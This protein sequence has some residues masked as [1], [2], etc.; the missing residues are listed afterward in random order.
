[1]SLKSSS[2]HPAFK[3]HCAAPPF[4]ILGIVVTKLIESQAEQWDHGRRRQILVDS[5]LKEIVNGQI[6]PGQHLVTQGLARRFGVSHT[7]VREAL[8]MLAGMGLVDVAPNRGAVVRRVTPREVREICQVRSA[9]ECEAVRL[10]CGR[11]DQEELEDLRGEL[12]AVGAINS[13]DQHVTIEVARAVDNRLH[14][15]ISSRCGNTFLAH[16]LSRLKNLFR[17]FR[18]AAWNHS[19][20]RSDFHRIS[21]EAKEHLAI[22]DSLLAIDR[23]RAVRAMARH[24]ASGMTYWSE[25]LP[26]SKA[27]SGSKQGVIRVCVEGELS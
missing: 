12:V 7:P 19:E 17:A 23:P 10:A 2:P 27:H 18:D 8:I 1:M 24:I 11:I 6:R 4:L 14:D 3:A 26:E 21:A 15:L 22:V 20:A 9:L 13:P 16:E 5:L 25:A